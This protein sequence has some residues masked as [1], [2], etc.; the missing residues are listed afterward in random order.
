MKKT[1][2]AQVLRAKETRW[3]VQ[4]LRKRVLKL[5]WSWTASRVIGI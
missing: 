5:L 4:T 1:S 2:K 3:M